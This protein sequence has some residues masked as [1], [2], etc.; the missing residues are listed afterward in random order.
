MLAIAGVLSIGSIRAQGFICGNIYDSEDHTPIYGATIYISELKTGASTDTSGHF[1]INNVPPGSFLG[2]VRMIGYATLA[3]T[4]YTVGNNGE[5]YHCQDIRLVKTPTEYH[6]VIITG[7]S[8]TQDRKRNPVPSIL[9]TREHLLEHSATNAVNALAELPGVSAISTG[10]AI[11]K[12]VIRGLGYNRV[13]V[14]RNG[15]RQEGQQWG[16]E[17]GVEIDEF[18]I[19][20]VEIIKG[21]GSIM[22]GSDAMAGVINFLTIRTVSQGTIGGEVVTG[23]QSNGMLLGNSL[24]TEGNLHGISWQIRG[25]Q[26][27]AGNSRTPADGYVANSGFREY[28]AS[29]FIG[30]NRTWGVSQI[31]FSTFNQL[32]GLPEGERDSLGRFL[33]ATGDDMGQVGYVPYSS[34]DL[35]GYKYSIV[36]PV[37]QINHNRIGWASSIYRN[38]GRFKFDAGFQQNTRKEFAEAGS[39]DAIAVGLKLTTLSFNSVYYT[40]D[41]DQDDDGGQLS[42]G[43]NL[44]RQQNKNIGSEFIIPEYVSHDAGV[45]AHYHYNIDEIYAGAGIRGDIRNV[46]S[47]ELYLDTSGNPSG[48][49]SLSVLKFESFKKYFTSISGIAGIS[50]QPNDVVVFRFNIS[51]GF[52]A[53]NIAELASNGKHEGTFRYEKGN[54]HLK[55]ESSLQID[56]GVVFT[57]D[58]FNIEVNGFTNSIQNYIYLSK[59]NSVFGGDSIVDPTDPAPLFTF[60][61][62][63]AQ[64]IGCE[65]TTDLHPHPLDWLHF[66]NSFAVVNGTL[67]NQ[68]DSM[69]NLPF[70]PPMKLQSEIHAHNENGK[71]LFHHYFAGLSGAYYFTQNRIYSA[72]GTETATP[73]YFILEASAG[74]EIVNKNDKTICTIS[75]HVNNVL[76]TKYQSH[77]SRLKYAPVNPATGNSGIYGQGRNFSV[78]LL[79]PFSTTV[80]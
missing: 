15:V 11:S 64:L 35:K 73:S 50:W 29:G 80:K 60:S 22:Y 48:N 5:Y 79:I 74:T 44:Q 40:N 8:G 54:S 43:L 62:G 63:K 56:L 10:N 25:S 45:F 13:V 61:Q 30:L 57:S 24:M 51:R 66:E 71:G 72:Y 49:D 58:H 18:E 68:P 26:K 2:E 65:I 67:L 16:D 76:D 20:R 3:V 38:K 1:Q 14:L 70:M 47:E 77:L 23:F 39:S 12:P 9:M 19:D 27:L 28:D 59:V 32:L 75:F 33:V 31:T 55:P 78:R 6:P 53:P 7:V 17:H 41:P 34:E 46:Q 37:Q 36:E 52:R 21:P 69:T 42:L 4:L